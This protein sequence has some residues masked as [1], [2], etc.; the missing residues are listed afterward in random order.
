[1]KREVEAFKYLSTTQD[2]KQ[3]G[4]LNILPQNQL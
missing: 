2:S 4:K 3:F 1:M